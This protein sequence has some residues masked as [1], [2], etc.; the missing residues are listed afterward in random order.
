MDESYVASLRKLTVR[1]ENKK[2]VRTPLMYT[3]LRGEKKMKK[4]RFFENEHV[5]TEDPE[6]L[7]E[8]PDVR[9]LH[10]NGRKHH[11]VSDVEDRYII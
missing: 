10:F 1:E 8:Y 2:K 6:I 3:F 7:E 11:H 9:L 4:V 5:D